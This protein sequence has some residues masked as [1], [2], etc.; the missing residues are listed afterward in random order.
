MN[1]A[2][3]VPS[4]VFCGWILFLN[5]QAEISGPAV[6][7]APETTNA[8]IPG[9]ISDG[10]PAPALPLPVQKPDFRIESTQVKQVDVVE[11]PELPE[12]PPV[13]GT[14]T[15][16]VHTVTDPGLPDPPPPL[17]SLSVTD[18][19]VKARLAETNANYKQTQ[20]VFLSAT[21]Y[22]HHRTLLTCYPSGQLGKEITA[23]SNLDFNHFCGFGDFEATGADGEVRKYALFMGI[24]NEKLERRSELLGSKGIE[25]EE[26]EIPALP[27]GKPA[28]VVETE[29]PDP[30]SMTLIEDLHALYRAEGV[31]MAEAYVAREK[32]REARKAYL[33]ANPPKPKDV[34]IHFWKREKSAA[35]AAPQ[36]GGRP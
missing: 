23:W 22:D 34:T 24:G 2:M 8:T 12:L 36:E 35:P 4:A 20:F 19:A 3:K 31:R 30:E 21:V 14:I 29:N 18:P 26:P 6:R 32:A 33:L 10:T 9:S 17:P 13:T 16:K 25:Y 1:E 15:I 28:F 11:A 5:L 7:T 27:D